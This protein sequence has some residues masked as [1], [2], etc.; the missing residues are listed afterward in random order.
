MQYVSIGGVSN[1]SM[2][3]RLALLHLFSGAKAYLSRRG[4][5]VSA[6]KGVRADRA[7]LLR[8]HRCMR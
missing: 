4:S 2:T 1:D 6:H 5:F 7:S 3:G 8:A